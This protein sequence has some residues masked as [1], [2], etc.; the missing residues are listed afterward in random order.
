VTLNVSNRVELAS[1]QQ[2]WDGM[3]ELC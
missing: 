1:K 3:Y 2:H